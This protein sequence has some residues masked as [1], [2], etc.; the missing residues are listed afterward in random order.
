MKYTF[1]NDFDADEE[2]YQESS[3]FL[4][5]KG[6][7]RNNMCIFSFIFVFFGFWFGNL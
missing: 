3:S 2:L 6:C 1:S 7:V 4:A 5:E